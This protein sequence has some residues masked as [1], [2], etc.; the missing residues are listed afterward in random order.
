MIR[1]FGSLIVALAVTVGALAI[2]RSA[3]ACSPIPDPPELAEY[4]DEIAVAFVGRQIDYVAHR[5]KGVT[6]VF[7][8]DRVYK[9]QAGPVVEL[10]TGYGGGDCG[11]DFGGYG[12]VGITAGRRGATGWWAAEEG[13]LTVS[14]HKSAATVEELEEVFGAGYPPDPTIQLSEPQTTEPQTTEPQTTEPQTT[15][16]QTTE[17]QT[18]EPSGNPTTIRQTVATGIALV[19]LGAGL[20]AIHRRRRRAGR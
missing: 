3:N 8:V 13:D 16:P 4:A 9:G 15:E 14:L 19:V 2:P 18:S 11:V 7:E 1:A 5:S 6:L 20:I 10:S 12:T 17:P